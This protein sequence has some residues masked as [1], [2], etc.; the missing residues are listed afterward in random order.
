MEQNDVDRK[1]ADVIIDNS[2]AILFRRLA[3]EDLKQRKMIY[4][5]SNISR[6]GY[7]AEDFINNRIMF[8]DIVYSQDTERTKKEIQNYVNKNIEEYTQT[9]RI[10]TRDGD[11][12]WIED[13]TS[14]VDDPETGIRYHQGI[15]IDIHRR[16]EAEEKL[17]KSE[18]KYRRIV[19]TTAEGFLLMD[20]NLIIV[21]MN[22]AYGRMTGYSKKELIGK[23]LLDLATEKYRVFLSANRDDLLNRQYYK[24]ESDLISRSGAIVPVLVHG[25]TLYDDMRYALCP[26]PHALC[27]LLFPP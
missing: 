19:E 6:F 25:N 1:Y 9:Y 3:A 14:V 12:R 2:P 10:V 13:R 5:S 17:R 24:F 8:R 15:V 16:K 22:N 4:V 23:S 7:T 27:P 21:D 20:K 18:E 11:V 26:M